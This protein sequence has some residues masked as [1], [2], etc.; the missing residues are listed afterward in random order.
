VPHVAQFG[1]TPED[2]CAGACRPGSQRGQTRR[3]SS[4]ARSV[5]SSATSSSTAHLR[6]SRPASWLSTS[7]CPSRPGKLSSRTGCGPAASMSEAASSTRATEASSTQPRGSSWSAVTSSGRLRT[8]S[9]SRNTEQPRT[10]R[11]PV[12]TVVLPAPGGP[13]TQIAQSCNPSS[14]NHATLHP[15]AARTVS[16]VGFRNGRGMTIPVFEPFEDHRHNFRAERTADDEV[17]VPNA[18][19]DDLFL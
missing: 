9:R 2:S 19:Y 10:T 15:T 6:P 3:P 16:V 1:T 14:R 4:R 12:T 13:A 11:S 7:S 5:A 8:S 17:H 18:G